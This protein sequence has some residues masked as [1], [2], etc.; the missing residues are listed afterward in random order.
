[1]QCYVVSYD[2]MDDKR[3]RRVYRI[4]RGYGDHI[5]YS[6]FRCELTDVQRVQMEEAL[7]REINHR[8]DQVLI[9]DVGPVPGRGLKSIESIGKALI[10]PERH[11][12]VI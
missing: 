11:A 5:Q 9:I 8:E 2:I 7:G 1:M 10:L 6:V 4:M 12:R 3:W